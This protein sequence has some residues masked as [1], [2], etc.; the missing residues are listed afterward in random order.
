[1]VGIGWWH[2]NALLTQWKFIGR[3][4]NLVFR[5]WLFPRFFPDTQFRIH[6]FLL[7]DGVW[8]A[9][10][11]ICQLTWALLCFPESIRLW[12]WS[13][14]DFYC[15][16]HKQTSHDCYLIWQRHSSAVRQ[17]RNRHSGL[18]SPCVYPN[19]C[20]RGFGHG[21]LL[22]FCRTVLYVTKMS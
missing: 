21:H 2:L 5:T 17:G 11:F 3:E 13:P 14:P 19:L 8:G 20:T 9:C 4:T 18:T 15:D 6:C 12:Q 16:F 10:A 22:W 7:E 1:M